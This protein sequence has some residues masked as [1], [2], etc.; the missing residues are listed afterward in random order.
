MHLNSNSF[1]AVDNSIPA[2]VTVFLGE[3]N[4]VPRRWA[5]K[6]YHKL[7][8]LH[9][10]DKGGHFAAWEQPEL[11]TEETRAAFGSLP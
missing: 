6:S 10:V 2:A 7:I 4:R 5:E 8:Y 9:E 11:F 3:I 1:N